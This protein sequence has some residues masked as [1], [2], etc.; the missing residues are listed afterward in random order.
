MPVYPAPSR[1]RALGGAVAVG[2][3][4]LLLWL[5]LTYRENLPPRLMAILPASL[6]KAPPPPPPPPIKPTLLKPTLPALMMPDIQLAEP[7]PKTLPKTLVEPRLAPPRFGPAD[8]NSLAITLN[9][10]NTGGSASRGE[11]GDYDGDVKRR[12]ARARVVPVLQKEERR[13][14]MIE[15]TVVIDRAGHRL[16]YSIEPCTIPE[17]NAAARTTIEN[18]PVFKIPPHFAGDTYTVH[19]T[20][21]F[22]VKVVE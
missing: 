12:L 9:T 11:L 17:I 6:I 8:G 21:N 18:V 2:A 15:Y 22:N 4:V 10:A 3:H 16:R 19:G 13:S 20:L 14:C 5:V 7:K 1:G